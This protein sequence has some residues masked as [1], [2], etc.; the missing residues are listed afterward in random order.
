[1]LVHLARRLRE[2]ESA[3]GLVADVLLRTTPA[4]ALYR[5]DEPRPLR[6]TR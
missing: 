5:R 4:G 1:M 3:V 6:P 2:A